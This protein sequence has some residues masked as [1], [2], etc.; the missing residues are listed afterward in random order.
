MVLFPAK[1]E[2]EILKEEIAKLEEEKKQLENQLDDA[3][4]EKETLEIKVE[5]LEQAN[6]V[7]L[8]LID[9]LNTKID[10]AVVTLTTD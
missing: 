3:A 1:T 9:N 2:V 6:E 7:T 5:E 4:K 8:K 10:K